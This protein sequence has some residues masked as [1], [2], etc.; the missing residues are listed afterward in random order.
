VRRAIALTLDR[1]AIVKQLFSDKAD[2]GNDSPFAPVYPSTSKL[3]QRHKDLRT[4]KQLLAAAG[5]PSGFS[6]TLTTEKT[7]EIPQLAQI[8]A[9]SVKPIG[10]KMSLKIL[11]STAYFA[12]KQVGPPSGWG[13]TPW[14]NTPINI[15]DWGSRAV[16]NVLLTSALVSKGV[17]NAAHFNNKAY[18]AL[19][20]QYVAA[21]TLADQKR[22]SRKIELLL[23]D[24]TPVIFPYFYYY[25]AAGSKKVSG[26]QADALGQVYLSHTSLS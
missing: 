23:L 11:T 24:Q 4:A 6:I 8:L 19:V 10:I 9:N 20:K 12:G 13:T 14:L 18:D 3:P 1:P 2:L 22:V 21:H 7:G 25:L 16:P 17:W 26:Y 5:Y 15:T